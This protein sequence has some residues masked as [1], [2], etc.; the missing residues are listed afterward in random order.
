[1]MKNTPAISVIIPVYNAEQ[2]LEECL[3]SL[4]SQTLINRLSFIRTAISK[5]KR[6]RE[7][8]LKGRFKKYLQTI[9]D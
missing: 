3:S 9:P 2:Y 4:Q 8:K 7:M 5:V 1:M 6:L